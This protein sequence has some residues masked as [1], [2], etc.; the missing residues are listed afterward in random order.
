[1]PG[2]C[3]RNGRDQFE[4]TCTLKG[5]RCA[6]MQRDLLMLL[7]A[8]ATGGAADGA[9]AVDEGRRTGVMDSDVSLGVACEHCPALLLDTGESGG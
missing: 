2:L 4:C 8:P 1:M 7:A 3:G 5:G 9:S 6:A